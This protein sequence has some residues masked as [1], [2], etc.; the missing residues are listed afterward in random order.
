MTANS[1]SDNTRLES[2]SSDKQTKASLND[3]FI[4][5]QD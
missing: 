1:I 4:K 5:Q 2:L 3:G